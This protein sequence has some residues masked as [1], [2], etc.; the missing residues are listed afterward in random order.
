MIYLSW[1]WSVGFF[2]IS[3]IFVSKSAFLTTLLTLGILS[4]T[5]VNAEFV[6]KPLILGISFSVSIF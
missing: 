1:S 2:S 3:V 5:E 4:L 6:D